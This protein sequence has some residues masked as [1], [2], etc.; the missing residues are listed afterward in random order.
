LNI[1]MEDFFDQRGPIG[2]WRAQQQAIKQFMELPRDL[3]DFVGRPV[4]LP[5]L[6][7]AMRLSELSVD[8]LRGVAEG[9]LEITY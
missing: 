8:K 3:Q 1:R 6:T 4:N 7:L 5:Y 2:S 9:L